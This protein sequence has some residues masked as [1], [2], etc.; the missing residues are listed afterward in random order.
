LHHDESA[1]API[2]ICAD[3][4]SVALSTRNA[5]STMLTLNS[6]RTADPMPGF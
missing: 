2:N 5:V 1:K 4:A 3:D 6:N